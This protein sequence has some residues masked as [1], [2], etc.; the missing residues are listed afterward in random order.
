MASPSLPL[1]TQAPRAAVNE[2]GSAL[3]WFA[4]KHSAGGFGTPDTTPAL[5]YA[6]SIGP[7]SLHRAIEPQPTSYRTHSHYHYSEL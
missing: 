4:L 6:R 2:F 7:I 1:F 3:R 5:D